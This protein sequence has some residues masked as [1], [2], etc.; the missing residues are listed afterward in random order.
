MTADEESKRIHF[1]HCIAMVTIIDF[2]PL[3]WH[4]RKFSY[5][6]VASPSCS[7]TECT[8]VLTLM[9]VYHARHAGAHFFRAAHE[10]QNQHRQRHKIAQHTNE[11]TLTRIPRQ[12]AHTTHLFDFSHSKTLKHSQSGICA[13]TL[14]S[15]MRLRY[16]S[17]HKRCCGQLALSH[18]D[19][20]KYARD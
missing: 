19:K 9:R 15:C 16:F 8:H 6:Y 11:Y 12:V 4:K 18:K 20:R 2:A 13:V 14:L 1:R 7:V 3:P 5:V 17:L 10:N